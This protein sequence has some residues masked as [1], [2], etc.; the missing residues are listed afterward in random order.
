VTADTGPS[1]MG[2]FSRHW[3]L[4]LLR[5]ILALLFGIFAFHRPGLT[6]AMLVLFFGVYALVDGIFS[7]SAAIGGSRNQEARW[8][9]LL[10]GLIGIGLGIVTLQAPHIT[11]VALMFFIAVW[12]LATGV[13]KI[14]AAIR[15]RREVSCEFWLVLSGL[16]GVI[17]AFVVMEWPAAGA[18]VLASVIGCFAVVMGVTL[19]MLSLKLRSLGRGYRAE[20]AEPPTRRAA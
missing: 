9:L 12:A 6:L 18:L 20:V 14:I 11:A 13:L 5:G 4:I 3:W 10:E 1:F 17:F 2:L 8:L 7:V 19:I 16:A 15:L